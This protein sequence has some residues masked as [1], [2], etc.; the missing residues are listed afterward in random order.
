MR[1]M[2]IL[3]KKKWKK[4]AEQLAT[5]W[6]QWEDNMRGQEPRAEIWWKIK[7][8]LNDK[9]NGYSDSFHTP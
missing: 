8:E 3:K 4:D 2:Y 7:A 9:L 5:Q 1:K 6:V